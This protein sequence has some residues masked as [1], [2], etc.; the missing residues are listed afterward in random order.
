MLLLY[1]SLVYT[2]FNDVT[3]SLPSLFA[4]IYGFNDLQIGMAATCNA[5]MY[6]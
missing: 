2:T 3:A 5:Q 1:N 4:E 6:T